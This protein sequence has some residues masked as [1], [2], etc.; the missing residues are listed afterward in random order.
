MTPVGNAAK[1]VNGKTLPASA[2]A[3]VPD[4]DKP[5]TWKLRID[6]AGH[7][8]GAIAAI[9]PKGYRGQ[10]VQIPPKDLPG[11]KKKIRAA[12][13]KFHPDKSEDDIPNVIRNTEAISMKVEE[14]KAIVD[15]LIA[16]QC[17]WDEE[18]RE[19]LN[20]LSDN[21]LKAMAEQLKKDQQAELVANAAK[22]GLTDPGGNTHT[23]NEEKGKWEMKPAEKQSTE[24][25]EN[26]DDKKVEKVE[27]PQTADEWLAE[28]PSEVQSAVR[29]AMA[30]EKAE[31][32]KLVQ[33]LVA[34]VK[35]EGERNRLGEGFMKK[36]LSDLKDV[37]KVLPPEPEKPI[38]NWA[39]AAGQGESTPPKL[40]RVGLP[41]EYLE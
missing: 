2:F 18:D 17:C 39:G 22:K 36:S 7:V 8:G 28:A 38:A 23:W 24:E 37:V 19:V 15:N 41:S 14:R 26:K 29:N 9:G 1:T 30:I 35:D 34:N 11:V 40:T 3:Y 16:N 13:R 31:K 4:K 10:K 21:K 25:V 12:W 6:D 27:K 33:Q 32:V 5:S 20:G